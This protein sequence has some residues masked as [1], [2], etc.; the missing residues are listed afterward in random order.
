M[1]SLRLRIHGVAAPRRARLA[2]QEQP[3]VAAPN[4]REILRLGRYLIDFDTLTF[5]LINENIIGMLETF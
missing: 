4:V 2:P 3:S 1:L 5:A